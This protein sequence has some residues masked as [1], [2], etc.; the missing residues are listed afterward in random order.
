MVLLKS[1]M[2]IRGVKQR[3]FRR[4]LQLLRRRERG[5]GK[6]S[7]DLKGASVEIIDSLVVVLYNTIYMIH[8]WSCCNKIARFFIP[9]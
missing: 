7:P 3:V 5:L 2:P 1:F 9:V 8:D 6:E 4:L